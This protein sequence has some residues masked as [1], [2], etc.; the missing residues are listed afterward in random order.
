MPSWIGQGTLYLLE[1]RSFMLFGT[2]ETCYVIFGAYE[3]KKIP[4]LLDTVFYVYGT[5]DLT[6]SSCT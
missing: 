5:L 3:Y 6:F 2:C 1:G 4:D